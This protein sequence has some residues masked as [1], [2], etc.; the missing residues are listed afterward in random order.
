MTT[1]LRFFDY[2]EAFDYY[3]RLIK[4]TLPPYIIR[5]IS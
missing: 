4:R 1:Y 2:D 5:I 3:C